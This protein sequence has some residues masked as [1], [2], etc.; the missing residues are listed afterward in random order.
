V[1][2]DEG[3]VHCPQCFENLGHESMIEMEAP[4][5]IEKWEHSRSHSSIDELME[6]LLEHDPTNDPTT[7]IELE[8]YQAPDPVA[9]EPEELTEIEKCMAELERI[10]NEGPH[11]L[12]EPAP[13][14]PARR[15]RRVPPQEN[16]SKPI[17]HDAPKRTIPK[18]P[19]NVR[20]ME[21][22]VTPNNLKMTQIT[23]DRILL[24]QVRSRLTQKY[25][26][27]RADEFLDT[28]YTTKAEIVGSFL[29]E[30]I[31]AETYD[32][33]IVGSDLDIC[34]TETAATRIKETLPPEYVCT[35]GARHYGSLTS[36]KW[37][38]HVETWELPNPVVPTRSL[39]RIQFIILTEAGRARDYLALADMTIVQNSFNG[40]ELYMADE[41]TL[42]KCG[43]VLTD[44]ITPRI[45]KYYLRGYRLLI[46]LTTNVADLIFA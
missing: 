2:R 18:R 30:I 21:V 11:A 26:I 22:E 4:I 5:E 14:V 40:R 42:E 28:I 1:V 25:S 16:V 35:H 17:D 37:I 33:E 8:K 6:D 34:A 32:S 24:G 45:H 38:R 19:D 10:G 23:A 27:T 20:E 43:T 15:R 39:A 31:H 29:L 46:P 44:K 7:R 36:H 41:R 13:A 3:R 12:V 9:H